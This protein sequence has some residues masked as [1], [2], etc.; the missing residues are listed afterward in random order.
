MPG[1]YRFCFKVGCASGKRKS[2]CTS[3]TGLKK[4]TRLALKDHMFDLRIIKRIY[5]VPELA[6]HQRIVNHNIDPAPCKE[7]TLRIASARCI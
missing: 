5:A 2:K 1:L 3:F 6:F 4:K 7:K